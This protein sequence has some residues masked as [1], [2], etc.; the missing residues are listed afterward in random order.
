MSNLQQIDCNKGH[1]YFVHVRTPSGDEMVA[2]TVPDSVTGL[3]ARFTTSKTGAAIH[4]N[5]D[6]LDLTGDP[7]EADLYYVDVNQALHQAHLKT[8]GQGKPFYVIYSKAGV[9]DF[10]ADTFVVAIGSNV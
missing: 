4:A 9:A 3:K 10:Q 8:L 6:D 1:R 5:L 2:P 7:T